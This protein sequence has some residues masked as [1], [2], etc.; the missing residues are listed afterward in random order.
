LGLGRNSN[1]VS[2]FQKAVELSQ[3]DSDAAASLAYAFTAV[4]KPSEA[5]KILGD[6][7][8]QSRGS[9]ISPYMVA[10]I[11][12][13]LGDKDRAFEFLEKSYA[14]KSTDLGY[15]VKA[16]LRLDSLRSDQ[17]FSSLLRRMGLDE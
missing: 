13:G 14:E 7:Q 10:V 9:Y 4:G 15:F 6:L 16:D 12:A 3:N 8:Q 1:A 17:R 5:R 11:W 2:E